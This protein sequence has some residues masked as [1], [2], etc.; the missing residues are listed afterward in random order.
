VRSQG[1]GPAR[2]FLVLVGSS[3]LVFAF[4]LSASAAAQG[5]GSAAALEKERRETTKAPP[6]RV[7][8]NDDL[9]SSPDTGDAEVASDVADDEVT[10][11]PADPSVEPVDPVRE[12]LDRERDKRA[13]AEREWRAR[14]AEARA[15]VQE[16]EAR[17]WRDVTRTEFY[18]G[19]PVQVKVKEFV[20]TEEYRQTKRDLAELQEEFRRTGLPPGWARE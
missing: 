18:K 4:I 17:C 3:V 5:L 12:E 20:E 13:V 16:A 15:R 8:T 6:A 14:F 1:P 2:R 11:P 9:P 19:I 7:I 10:T